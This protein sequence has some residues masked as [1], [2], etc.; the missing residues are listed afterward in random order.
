[1]TLVTLQRRAPVAPGAATCR[2]C[3]TA[4]GGSFQDHLLVGT[5]GTAALRAVICARCGDCMAGLVELC[6]SDLRILVND[7]QP[8]IQPTDEDRAAPA[9]ELDQTRH[10]LTREADTL[11]RTAQS[12][13]AE[14]DKLGLVR[15]TENPNER[16]PGGARGAV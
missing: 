13:R 4:L 7:D 15:D 12:L 8:P 16:E 6:G 2:L 3:E 14:A 9:A 1:M 10:R 5:P 11:G